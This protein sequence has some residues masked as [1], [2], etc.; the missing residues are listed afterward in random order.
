MP[1]PVPGAKSTTLSPTPIADPSD[2]IEAAESC[3][4]ICDPE[5]CRWFR[6]LCWIKGLWHPGE[7]FSYPFV[8]W[9]EADYL[10]WSIKDSNLPPLVTSSPAGTPRGL[11]GVIGA[12]GTTVLFGG[13]G[14]DNEERSG[15]R[16]TA[17]FWFD[18][19]QCLGIE[20]SYFF[21]GQRSIGFN[22]GSSGSP[23]LA[24]P[25]FDVNA[26]VENSELVAFPGVLAGN[27]AV[28][29]T[30]RL[31]GTELDLRSNWCGGCCWRIDWLTG[32][33]YVALDESLNI[34]ENLSVPSGPQAGTSLLVS[35]SFG[36]HNSFAGGQVGMEIELRQSRWSLT[37][38]GKVALGNMH[39][40]VNIN[41][42]TTFLVP[43]LAPNVQPGGLLALPTNIGRYERDRF[44]VVPEAG[45][46]IGYQFSK[47]WRAF[48]GYSFLYL[49]DV[50]RPGNQI[51]RGI[52]VTQLPSVL[53]PGTL[54]GAARPAFMFHSTDFW[55][56][57]VNFGL[58]FRW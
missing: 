38:L 39:E 30:S 18:K 54:V 19:S 3:D 43:G 58:E 10:L 8:F 7:C 21:L 23:I 55:A 57:G 26:G 15:A 14:L 29:A 20:G 56:Q 53:G 49:S 27:V 32:F 34:S 40:S 44:A 24:R 47:R 37:L 22:A 6:P 52:N 36:T 13:N 1:Q 2:C 11:A 41:G 28:R 50:V 16:I 4:D 45:I 51:D 12:P 17:G 25:F 48:I 31:W 42:S 5:C 46:K 33:R 35:D 9:A